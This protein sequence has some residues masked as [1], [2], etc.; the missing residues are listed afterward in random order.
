MNSMI[1]S[2][3]L[4]ILLLL[5]ACAEDG[6]Q[7]ADTD[8]APPAADQQAI[9]PQEAAESQAQETKTQHGKTEDL[10]AGTQPAKDQQTAD[11]TAHDPAPA[12]PQADAPQ[13]DAQSTPEQPGVTPPSAPPPNAVVTI[14]NGVKN[15]SMNVGVVSWRDLPFQTVRHQAFDYSCGS[16]AVATLMTYTYNTPTTEEE[17]FEDMFAHGNKDKIRREGFSMLDMARYLNEHGL[18]AKGF[19]LD[20]KTIMAKHMPIIA[21]VNNKGYNHFV[22][23][24]GAR[25][26]N[27]VVGDPNTGNTQYS[28]QEFSKIWNGIALVVVNKASV[29]REAFTDEKEWRYVHPHGPVGDGNDTWNDLA[30]L[31]AMNW[32][33]N[34]GISD[35]LP[36]TQIGTVASGASGGTP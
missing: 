11:K 25:G 5:P 23:V 6:I 30:Q 9:T 17:V 33:L 34:P 36:I 4:I 28:P 13:A 12:Q 1:R 16:A 10:Q 20:E 26:N 22:V 3:G 2:L 7:R 19:K 24:K 18:D 14:D 21:L 32:Q 31:D 15:E 35:M 8:Q 27:F 29:A